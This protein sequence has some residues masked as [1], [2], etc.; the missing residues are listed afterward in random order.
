MSPSLAH[1]ANTTFEDAYELAQCLSQSSSIAEALTTYEN[2]RIP[3]TQAIQARS[4]L[5]EQR[6]YV[7]DLGTQ[8]P[9]KAARERVALEE[10]QSW[11]YR[12]DPNSESRLKPLMEI[13]AT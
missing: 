7:T 10:F 4:A 1:G 12:Y 13:P 9:E 11:V 6:S 2:R 3:R 5:T 8:D